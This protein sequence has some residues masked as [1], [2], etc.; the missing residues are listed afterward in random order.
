MATVETSN[1]RSFVDF[2]KEEYNLSW[3]EYCALGDSTEQH[4]IDLIEEI[5]DAYDKEIENN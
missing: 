5:L 3:D 1:C 4:D 2:L